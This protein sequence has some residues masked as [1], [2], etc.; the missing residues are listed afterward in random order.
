MKIEKWRES[1][2]KLPPKEE[3]SANMEAEWENW[4]IESAQVPLLTVD[5]LRDNGYFY[6]SHCFLL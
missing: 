6:F 2:P 4:T 5:Y 1:W 3:N